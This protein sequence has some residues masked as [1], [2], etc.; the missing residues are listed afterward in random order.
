MPA[1]ICTFLSCVLP[2]FEKTTVP[3]PVLVILPPSLSPLTTPLSVRILLLATSIVKRSSSVSAIARVPLSVA[4]SGAD[5]YL[6]PELS[7]RIVRLFAKVVAKPSFNVAASVPE[8]R[9]T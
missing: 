7:V 3:A 4:V 1:L 6:M 5:R 2:A 9:P 8:S